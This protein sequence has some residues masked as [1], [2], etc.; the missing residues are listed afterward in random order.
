[1]E[2]NMRPSNPRSG[3]GQRGIAV[4]WMTLMLCT[5]LLPMVGLAIDLTVL[6][7]VQ[8]KLS[9]A[10]DG[11]ALG[12]GRLLNVA[13]SSSITTIATQFVNANFP[14]GFW[15][16]TAPVVTA[17][18][19]NGLTQTVQVSATAVVPLLFMRILG[20]N[21]A[22][23]G[24][25][26]TAT[27]RA[28]RIELVID[29]SGSMTG[30]ESDLQS[31]AINNLLNALNPGYDEVGLVIFDFSAAVVYPQYTV[32]PYNFSPTDSS[33]PAGPDVNFMTSNNPATGT[34]VNL[35]NSIQ[36]GGNT[37]TAEA[38]SLAYIELQ[39]AHV[40]DLL[41]NGTDIRT[42]AIVLFTDGG[43]NQIAVNLNQGGAD[44]T[45]T[46]TNLS[47]IKSSSSCS[48]QSTGTFTGTFTGTGT[49][50]QMRGSIGSWPPVGQTGNGDLFQ[51][52]SLDTFTSTGS[53]WGAYFATHPYPN[54][55]DDQQIGQT[56]PLT[57]CAGTPTP[58]NVN[59]LSSTQISRIPPQDLYGNST[60]GGGYWTSSFIDQTGTQQF[61]V[62]A[63]GYN[64]DPT[65][66][67][68]TASKVPGSVNIGNG[69]G[70]VSTQEY[71]LQIAA[72]N[73]LDNAA[74][75]IRGD[76]YYTGTYYQG[77]DT[78]PSG[79]IGY[80]PYTGTALRTGAAGDAPMKI[81]IL[82]I[83]YTGNGG[84]D[85]TLLRR[86]ANDPSSNVFDTN[87]QEGIYV[88]ANNTSEMATAF[89]AVASELLRL[90]Q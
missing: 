28:S 31:A 3:S 30:V 89:A 70:P 36:A 24:S 79:S 87:Q 75:N 82:V 68:T 5:F 58:S 49:A 29:R 85:D 73:A 61:T 38:L 72:W 7:S 45:G 33:T 14:T 62:Y 32:R 2:K 40:K 15:G 19:T 21:S 35:I 9:A 76:A 78:G 1:M 64:Y 86:V 65:Q 54:S 17:T 13:S 25:T 47:V 4:V 56:T 67:V 57:G 53:Y 12:A 44:P 51:L 41:A 90:A 39:K 52:A 8:S 23:V 20:F 50:D 26:G 43:A 80:V 46:V 59:M 48:F 34:M 10:V 83:G 27:R 66:V 11:G 55:S 42:N 81:E 22:T 63:T 60:N 18:Y 69:N 71:E 37:G 84:V 77:V 74:M 88:P 16:S 6:Y